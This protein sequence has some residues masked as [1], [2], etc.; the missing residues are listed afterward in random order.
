[1]SMSFNW[2]NPGRSGQTAAVTA[3]FSK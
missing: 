1:V 2:L 3:V